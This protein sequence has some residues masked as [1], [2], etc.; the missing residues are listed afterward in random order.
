MI[1]KAW[2]DYENPKN[3]HIVGVT[4]EYK[5]WMVMLNQVGTMQD[6]VLVPPQGK[7]TPFNSVEDAIN[8]VNGVTL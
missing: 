6:V 2:V 5:G 8:Y 1:F 4:F 7:A 3:K